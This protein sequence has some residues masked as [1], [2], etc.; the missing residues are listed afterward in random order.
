MMERDMVG[1][2]SQ[3]TALTEHRS[4]RLRRSADSDSILRCGMLFEF[5][6]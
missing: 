5:S 1:D 6:G 2:K 4:Y 3:H